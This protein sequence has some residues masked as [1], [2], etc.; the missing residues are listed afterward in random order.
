MGFPVVL[1]SFDFFMNLTYTVLGKWK[2]LTVLM[3]FRHGTSSALGNGVMTGH[4]FSTES[5]SSRT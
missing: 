2:E 5:C 4:I 3:H 1:N